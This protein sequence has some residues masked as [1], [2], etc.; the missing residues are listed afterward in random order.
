[1]GLQVSVKL[2]G[3]Y[4]EVRARRFSPHARHW[5]RCSR[6]ATR[7]S[8]SVI[9]WFLARH[10]SR[11]RFLILLSN[12][13]ELF[14]TCR[15]SASTLARS[16]S[17]RRSTSPIRRQSNL[18]DEKTRPLRPPPTVGEVGTPSCEAE[19]LVG[20][21]LKPNACSPIYRRHSLSG[22]SSNCPGSPRQSLRRRLRSRCAWAP[23]RPLHR[24]PLPRARR[25]R[26][27]R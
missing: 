18:S 10:F 8:S 12:S 4:A 22:D 16:P 5:R 14:K 7:S 9:R 25:R 23:A 13:T 17:M 19:H 24:R 3:P 15:Y 26:N 1:L 20:P 2:K 27:G 21:F 11:Q 6:S